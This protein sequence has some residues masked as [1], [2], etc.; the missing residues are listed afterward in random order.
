MLRA[1]LFACLIGSVATPALGG[2]VSAAYATRT[3]RVGALVTAADVELRA[4]P[5]HRAAGVIQRLEEAIGREV[6]RNLY[7]DRPIE[8][9]DLGVP[10]VVHRNNLV[11]LAYRR[12]NIEIRTVGRALD[13]AGLHEMVRVTN[14]DSRN[15]VVGTVAAPG[16]VQV[17][18]TGA[19]P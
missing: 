2:E 1:F 7:A 9:G 12:G 13:S 3:L 10:T 4:L 5:E 17:G 14:L 19:R 18:P 11:T 15:T 8:A 6:R 16:V